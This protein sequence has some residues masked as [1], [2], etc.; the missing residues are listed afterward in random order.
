VACIINTHRIENSFWG[1]TYRHAQVQL[2]GERYDGVRVWFTLSEDPRIAPKSGTFVAETRRPM[3]RLEKS[4]MSEVGILTRCGAAYGQVIW[5]WLF[6]QDHPRR[7]YRRYGVG[8][9]NKLAIPPSRDVCNLTWAQAMQVA[10]ARCEAVAA[11]M[12]IPV[13][14]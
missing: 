9:F 2:R 1:E 11:V 6:R 8:S 5:C 10:R 14:L 7:R 4:T 3:A 13:A 12:T